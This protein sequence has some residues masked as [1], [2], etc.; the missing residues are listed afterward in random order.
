M[1]ESENSMG[2]GVEGPPGN[3]QPQPDPGSY[4]AKPWGLG[5]Y[6]I[7]LSII[8]TVLIYLFW[9][10][11][12][13]GANDEVLSKSI[14]PIGDEARLILLVLLAGAL[15][16]YIHAA[17]SFVTFAGNRSLKSSWVWWYVLRPF[18]GSTLAL[19]FYFIIRGGF[20]SVGSEV[21]N[22]SVFGMTGLAGLVGMFSK[23]AI[24]KLKEV[25]ETL[26]KGE[27]DEVRTDKA[28]DK[29]LV[30]QSMIPVSKIVSYK[31]PEGK[32]LNEILL[33]EIYKL[34]EGVVTRVPIFTEK[35]V[36]KYVIH[37][38][39]IYRFIAVNSVKAAGT[40]KP[41]DAKA[42]TLEDLFSDPEIK[43]LIEKS[44]VFVNIKATI[45]EAKQKMEGQKNCQDVFV[46]E[47]G[48][49]VEPVK[50]WLTNI[51]IVKNMNA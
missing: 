25:F 23:N 35:N 3:V 14:I 20:L 27:G 39:V 47:N 5:I 10:E 31:I 37:Q 12:S 29:M 17:T 49:P 48:Q 4:V 44:I 18:I 1:G 6:L 21:N 40:D 28:G 30:E 50:G 38:S 42:A 15:G 24:D 9:P 2:K 41:F 32:P 19:I 33:Q 7:L 26:F 11:Y 34:Y 36:A 46:T 22:I 13:K 51:D 45:G 16:S 43:D 8:L